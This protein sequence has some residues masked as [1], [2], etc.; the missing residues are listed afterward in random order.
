MLHHGWLAAGQITQCSVANPGIFEFQTSGFGATELTEGVLNVALIIPWARRNSV[1]INDTP[2]AAFKHK[3]L[4]IVRRQV[5]S[6]LQRMARTT[7]HIKERYDPAPFVV[8]V[9][10]CIVLQP[11]ASV[12]VRYGGER[13]FGD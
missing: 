11:S 3:P 7:W 8:Q 4:L 13:R 10:V 2:A 1:S 9:C 12:P 6:Q 5:E